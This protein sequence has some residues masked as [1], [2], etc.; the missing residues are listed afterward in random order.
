MQ[1]NAVQYHDPIHLSVTSVT[2]S[3]RPRRRRASRH[4]LSIERTS[5]PF[6]VSRRRLRQAQR[7]GALVQLLMRKASSTGSCSP[8][9]SAFVCEAMPT[10]ARKSEYC[11][12]VMPFARAAAV[13]EWMQ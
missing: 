3:L 1:L 11:A 6:S 8:V 5:N 13:W 2:N 10:T 4:S 9:T 7:F 12:S